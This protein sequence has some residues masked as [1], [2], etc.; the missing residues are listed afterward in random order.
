MPTVQPVVCEGGR[1]RVSLDYF[2][3]HR[4]IFISLESTEKG[5]LEIMG[6]NPLTFIP[7]DDPPKKVNHPLNQSPP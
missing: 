3:N 5:A 4:I 7:F 2:K 6:E 1:T